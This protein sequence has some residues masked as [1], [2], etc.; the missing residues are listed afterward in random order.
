MRFEAW[1]Q[2]G[3]GAIRK[4]TG[5]VRKMILE[6]VTLRKNVARMPA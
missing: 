5:I 1:C 2:E 4:K 6:K 3:N